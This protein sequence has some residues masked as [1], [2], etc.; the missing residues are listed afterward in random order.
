LG[1]AVGGGGGGREEVRGRAGAAVVAGDSGG[2]WGR[3]GAAVDGAPGAG[4]G[5]KREMEN[6]PR[7]LSIGLHKIVIP[8]G[9]GMGRRE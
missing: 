3:W 2:R 7:G 1:E 9:Q 6:E 5:L 4:D 8:V